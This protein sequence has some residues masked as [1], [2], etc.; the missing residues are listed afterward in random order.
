[1]SE[2]TL[3]LSLHSAAQGAFH[4]LAVGGHLDAGNV[5]RFERRTQRLLEERPERLVLRLGDLE[6]I[7]SAGIGVLLQVN[8]TVSGYGG[9][10]HLV[11]MP[12]HLRRIFEVLGFGKVFAIA[13]TLDDVSQPA[14]RA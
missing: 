4:V 14:G 13:A 11:E 1:M 2:L 6:Y 8:R 9:R 12:D 7:S 5:Q 3:S 10:L